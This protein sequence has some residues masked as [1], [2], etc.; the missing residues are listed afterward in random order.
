[1]KRIMVLSTLLKHEFRA[2][3]VT[4]ETHRV[5]LFFLP[6]VSFNNQTITS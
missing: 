1:M 2:A 4:R 6:H 5:K 3:C